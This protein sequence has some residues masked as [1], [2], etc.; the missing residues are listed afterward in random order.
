VK[1]LVICAWAF[2]PHDMWTILPALKRAGLGF[3]VISSKGIVEEEEARVEKPRKF[4]VRTLDEFDIGE[5]EDYDGLIFV[6][7]HRITRE[8]LYYDVKV[9]HI[10]LTFDRQ[11]KP[12]AAPCAMVP[13]MRYVLKDQKCTVFPLTI[14]VS[15]LKRAGA[16]VL[17][18]SLVISGRYITAQT[19]EVVERM[20]DEF[21]R[22][23]KEFAHSRIS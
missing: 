1:V 23:V 4:R 11:N 6:S 17:D 8:R 19:E 18:E 3:E 2:N 20:V 7:G 12:I 9:K 16:E 10:V 5:V 14:C 21:I 15:L 13:C 22:K